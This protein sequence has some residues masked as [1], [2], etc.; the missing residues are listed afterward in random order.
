MLSEEKVM[1]L[2]RRKVKLFAR[3][4]NEKYLE[5][6]SV[7]EELLELTPSQTDEMLKEEL[8]KLEK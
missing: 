8:D 3:T 4:G 2:L 5:A 1:A 6:I 7:L